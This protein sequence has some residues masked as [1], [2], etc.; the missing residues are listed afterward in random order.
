M[1]ILVSFISLK[2]KSKADPR[3]RDLIQPRE[4]ALPSKSRIL[5]TVTAFN[6]QLLS[7]TLSK[8]GLP[9]TSLK[10]NVYKV[11]SGFVFDLIITM[12]TDT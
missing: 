1:P 7:L 9:V 5:Q 8:S 3:A 12:L 11:Q 4:P 6:K 2:D 10:W